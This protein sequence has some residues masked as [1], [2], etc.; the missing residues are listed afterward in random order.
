MRG[1]SFVLFAGELTLTS[2]DP[3][4]PRIGVPLSSPGL[5]VIGVVPTRT[6]ILRL[7]PIRTALVAVVGPDAEPGGAGAGPLLSGL[8][9]RPGNPRLRFAMAQGF[10]AAVE[11]LRARLA[12]VDVEA[13]IVDGDPAELVKRAAGDDDFVLDGV[14][15][16]KEVAT[17]LSADVGRALLELLPL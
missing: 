12:R 1:G 2:N 5:G 14:V 10:G 9:E 6:G 4:Q 13:E 15:C 17:A 16:D 3:Q 8:R 7:A 11:E